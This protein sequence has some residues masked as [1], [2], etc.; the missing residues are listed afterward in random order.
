MMG[1]I[2]P[3]FSMPVA[4]QQVLAGTRT[5]AATNNGDNLYDVMEASGEICDK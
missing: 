1:A 3:S 2:V 4:G 5:Q